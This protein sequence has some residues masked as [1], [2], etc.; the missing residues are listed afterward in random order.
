M[1]LSC[2][3]VSWVV[4]KYGR[5]QFEL[6]GALGLII[7]VGGRGPSREGVPPPLVGALPG[8]M[9]LNRSGTPV[10]GELPIWPDC[11]EPDAPPESEPRPALLGNGLFRMSL[12]AVEEDEGVKTGDWFASLDEPIEFGDDVPSFVSLLFLDDLLGSLPR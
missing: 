6:T 9:L 7:T 3:P 2:Q 5:E 12:S 10:L 4:A 11:P 8:L 1:L